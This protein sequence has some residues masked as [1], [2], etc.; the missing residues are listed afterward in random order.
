MFL[1]L[2]NSIF[3]QKEERDFVRRN[4]F[5]R[6]SKGVYVYQFDPAKGKV[7]PIQSITDRESPT[8]LAIHPSG[9]YLYTVNRM[10]V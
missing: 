10:A 9:K 7:T 5:R 8:F 3:A 1:G 2:F 6:E 4:V